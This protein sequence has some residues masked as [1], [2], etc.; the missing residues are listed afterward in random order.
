MLKAFFSRSFQH[1]L[2]FWYTLLSSNSYSSLKHWFPCLFPREALPRFLTVLCPVIVHCHG[3]PFILQHLPQ[4]ESNYM[5]SSHLSCHHWAPCRGTHKYLLGEY[6]NDMTENSQMI[7]LWHLW[8]KSQDLRCYLPPQ[9]K[10]RCGA[11]Y[12]GFKLEVVQKIG[13][14]PLSVWLF[15]GKKL[16]L[17]SRCCGRSKGFYGELRMCLPLPQANVSL[18][19]GH[20]DAGEG[21]CTREQSLTVGRKVNGCS[22]RGKWYG[23]SSKN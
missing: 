18:C 12:A 9:Y 10:T 23:G 11:T 15:T 7:G 6:T 16:K 4:L 14:A 22:H 8:M 5:C 13:F 19:E 20:S 17:R 3:Y 2:S 1:V 21:V